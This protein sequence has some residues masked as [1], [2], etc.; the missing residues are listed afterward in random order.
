MP[1]KR[2]KR[3]YPNRKHTKNLA[4][5]VRQARIEQGE[6][7]QQFYDQLLLEDTDASNSASDGIT[8]HEV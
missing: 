7:Q 3:S 2:S 5:L 4:E 1:S 6:L 8:D